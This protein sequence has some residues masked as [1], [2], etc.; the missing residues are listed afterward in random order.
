V[1][2]TVP[3]TYTIEDMKTGE[4]ILGKMYEDEMIQSQ[5]DS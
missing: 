2:D 3:N 1:H 5:F 4:P